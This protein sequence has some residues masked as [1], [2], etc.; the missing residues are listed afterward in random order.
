MIEDLFMKMHRSLLY[1]LIF[2]GTADA[3]KVF[4]C[5]SCG[6]GGDDPMIL[7]PWEN[8]KVYGGFARTADF[9]TMDAS[10]RPGTETGP[11]ARNTTLVSMGHTWNPRLFS[12]LSAPY[13]VNKRRDRQMSGW[14]DPILASRY[15]LIPQTMADEAIPQ[16]QLLGSLRAGSAT[17]VYETQDPNRLDVRGSGLPE[18]RAGIDVW[19]GMSDYKAGLAQT[20]T[21]PIGVKITDVGEQKPGVGFRTTL[22]AGRGWGDTAKC[23]AGINR[24]YVTSRQLNGQPIEDSDMV[25]HSIFVTADGKVERDTTVRVTW[26]K[27]AA[28]FENRNVSRNQS[29][30][31]AM[32]RAF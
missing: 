22:T 24:E 4:A 29:F 30:T 3:A 18:V 31:L 10:G 28:V 19:Q 26:S 27:A 17:S 5:A 2:F 9:E 11:E 25:S 14:G 16:I 21:V 1:V 15:T 13:I 23:I 32:M 7:Y 8:W 6:S 12:T 20:I